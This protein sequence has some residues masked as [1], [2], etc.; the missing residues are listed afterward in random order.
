MIIAVTSSEEAP[1]ASLFPPNMNLRS[2]PDRPPHKT[3]AQATSS[4]PSVLKPELK[5]N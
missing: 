3:P 2:A 1:V 5:V 4:A